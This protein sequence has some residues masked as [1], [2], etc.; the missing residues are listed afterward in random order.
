MLMKS[1][2][3]PNLILMFFLKVIFLPVG[4]IRNNW[5]HMVSVSGGDGQRE[6]VR[7]R[8]MG[9]GAV[10]MCDC[11][12]G[13]DWMHMVLCVGAD[14][15][16]LESVCGLHHVQGRLT[17]EDELRTRDERRGPRCYLVPRP[18][19]ERTGR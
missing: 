1:I 11:S 17:S 5:D 7:S 4:C 9:H 13:N 19:G 14:E 6:F 10:M 15:Y 2:V 3:F 8:V 16:F 12:H 18:V